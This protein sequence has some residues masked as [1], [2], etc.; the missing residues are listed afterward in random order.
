MMMSRESLLSRSTDLNMMARSHLL[1]SG[2]RSLTNTSMVNSSLQVDGL[3]GDSGG[4]SG[5][6]VHVVGHHRQRAVTDLMEFDDDRWVTNYLRFD[7]P[8]RSN[9]PSHILRVLV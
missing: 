1:A 6:G 9:L 4:D 3:I 5:G 7:F 8:H 2:S